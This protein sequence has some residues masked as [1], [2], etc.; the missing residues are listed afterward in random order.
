MTRERWIGAVLMSVA[1]LSTSYAHAHFK[2]LKPSS[3][4]NEDE[5]GGPQKGSPCG[6]GNAMPFVGDDMN[7]SPLSK[8]VTTFHAGET[9]TVELKET[10]YHPG[11][12]RVSF[13]PKKAADA[14]TADFPN[15][16]LTDPQACIY[17][18]SAVKS[19][20]HDNVL[21]DGMFMVDSQNGTGRSLM[22]DVKLPN[23]PCE[24]CSLQ[25]V[26]VMEMHG[27]SSCYYFHCADIK[28]VAAEGGSAGS[29]PSE[30]AGSMSAG[31]GAT[32]PAKPTT[33]TKPNATNTS[34]SGCSIARL[35]A[36][37]SAKAAWC[38]VGVAAVLLRRRRAHRSLK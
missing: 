11:Y 12:F 31:T 9:V 16:A 3:W 10:V 6:P 4:L 8:A 28:I 13:A 7:P 14:T 26:Q 37:E 1:L 29:T 2:L 23:E 33:P 21:A 36:R 34:D 20:P 24:E 17:D 18:K 19:A 27:G 30:T 5:L 15:P 25:V 38:L 32:T 22:Q 35:G